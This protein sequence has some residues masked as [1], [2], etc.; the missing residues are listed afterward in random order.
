MNS[1]F[2]EIRPHHITMVGTRATI[3]EQQ[4]R[5][6]KL[7]TEILFLP[8][9]SPIIKAFEYESIDTINDVLML[10]DFDIDLL[11]YHKDADDTESA[12][13]DTL[14]RGHRGWIKVLIA[15]IKYLDFETESQLEEVN[16][17]IFNEYRFKI[18]N[19]NGEITTSNDSN[20]KT[21]NKV[22]INDGDY[23]KKGT[24]RDK[25][26]YPILKFDWQWD[27]WNR[28]TV[29]TAKTHQ[30]HEVFDLTYTP[31][32]KDEKSKF[33]AQQEFIYSV[34]QEKVQTD[35]GKH[36]VRNHYE[37]SD[38]QQIYRE[39]VD[40]AKISTHATIEASELMRYITNVRLH[41]LGWKGTH[42]SFILHW[43]DKLRLYEELIPIQD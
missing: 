4:I 41:T 42:H 24:K 34:F 15:F 33:E 40:H 17:D 25:S 26:Q 35:I 16:L 2:T 3:N 14:S 31:K 23:F 6:K 18:Y 32:T 43:C 8:E 36:S 21:N 19:P 9:D 5:F 28:T 11:Q 13:K 29:S 1:R 38:A 39:L 7:L 37:T 12:E 10:A 20:N 27:N 22:N 30:C